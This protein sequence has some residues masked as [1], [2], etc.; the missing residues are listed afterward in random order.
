VDSYTLIPKV[1]L[2][3]NHP[4]SQKL[5]SLGVHDFHE[6]A[7]F[8]HNI[9]YGYNSNYEDPF[10]LF[11]EN[12]GSCTSKHAV[13]AGL[14]EELNVPLYKNIGIY[15]MTEDLVTGTEKIL[16]TYSIPFIPM[17]HCF[18]SYD[19]YRFDLT[20]GNK[21]GKNGPIEIFIQTIQVKANFSQKEEYLWY[22]DVLSN[23]ILKLPE[24]KQIPEK[25]ILKARQD[26]IIL[27]KSKV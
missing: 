20:E 24:M 23:I 21:N 2:S 15:K 7:V 13:F 6:A 1:P 17:I 8:I 19:N 11:K 9:P 10:I 3:P 16:K 5:L 4:F 14:A 25:T 22:K 18:L 12:K 26:G 27:L